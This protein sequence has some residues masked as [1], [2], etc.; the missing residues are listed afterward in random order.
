MYTEIKADYA[1]DS[2]LF[3]WIQPN[4]LSYQITI[5][6]R[7]DGEVGALYCPL[8]GGFLKHTPEG[9]KLRKKGDYNT[10]RARIE[11][12]PPRIRAWING[13]Q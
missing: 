12:Q 10:V 7:P 9:V 6:C 1:V 3:L 13:S 2:G 5:D 8:G 11:G 4:V